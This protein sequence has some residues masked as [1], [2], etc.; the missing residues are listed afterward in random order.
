MII[1][2]LGSWGPRRTGGLS[3]TNF[4]CQ[5]ASKLGI[6]FRFVVMLMHCIRYLAESKHFILRVLR[7][8]PCRWVVPTC[9]DKNG[10]GMMPRG[11]EDCFVS[12]KSVPAREGCWRSGFRRGAKGDE[13][14]S[15]TAGTCLQ[16]GS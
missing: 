6:E 5:F 13:K 1:N 2:E 8:C 14:K 11:G 4:S 16:R 3:V 7:F 10:E 15:A 9:V 12:E